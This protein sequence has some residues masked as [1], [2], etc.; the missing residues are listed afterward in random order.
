MQRTRPELLMPLQ[1]T[2]NELVA[3]SS[4]ITTY[5]Q[6]LASTPE[7]AAQN[8]D[9]IALLDRFQ[10]RLTMPQEGRYERH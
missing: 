6:W 3:V 1:A 4:A 10:K 9:T 8:Q 2:A 5:Q 7:S